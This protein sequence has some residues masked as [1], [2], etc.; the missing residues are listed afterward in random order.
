[1]KTKRPTLR[2]VARESG[3]SYQTVSRVINDDPHV[4][5]ATRSRV[6]RAIKTLGFRPNR[7]AQILQTERSH[8]I[9][10]VMFY[11]GFNLFLYEMARISQLMGYHFVISAI[12]E[13]EFTRTLESAASRFVDGLIIVP[14]TPLNQDYETLMDLTGGIPFV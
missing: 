6:Q 8:T 14:K 9:E 12:T 2:D 7:A 1:M 4:S 11:F 5:N 13:Q 10:V 3:V